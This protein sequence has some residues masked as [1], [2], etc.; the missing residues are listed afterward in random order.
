MR[1]ATAS[2]LLL[3]LLAPGCARPAP[4]PAPAPDPTNAA[5]PQPAPPRAPDPAVVEVEAED[6]G[7]TD[8]AVEIR[9]LAREAVDGPHEELALEAGRP[10]FYA[11]A[12]EASVEPRLIGHLHGVCGAPSYACGKW[13]GAG[14]A[15]GIMVCPTGNARCGDP[16][17]GPPS[18][19][20]PSWGE[21][22]GI[23]DKDLEAAVA[24]VAKKKPLSREGAILTGYSR[25]AYAAPSIAR[26]HPKRWRH[27]VLIEA[28]AP[29][30][31]AGLRAAGVRSVALIAGEHGTEI[32]GMKKTEAALEAESFPAKL[33]VMR[34]TGHPYSADMEDVMSAALTFVLTH[35]T[36]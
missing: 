34:K 28:N 25:G 24:K 33:F 8:A 17:L 3:L 2:K 30:T 13:I 31:P 21:L 15:A 9:P 4:A 12:K 23:M 20:A 27:L 32:R 11:L 1:Q 22:V 6:A 7:A 35:D 5:A 26:A 36:D 29:L 10:V 19:E 14:S 18:W 16:S